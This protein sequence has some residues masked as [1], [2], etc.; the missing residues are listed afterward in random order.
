MRKCI[1]F[2][3]AAV[4]CLLCVTMTGC[5]A[6]IPELLS[7]VSSSD[8]LPPPGTYAVS[9]VGTMDGSTMFYTDVGDELFV[10]NP[11]GT[12]SF[13]YDGKSY[14]ILLDGSKLLVDGEECSYRYVV[15]ETEE[16]I[17]FLYWARDD[18]N[19]I[20]LRPVVG[21]AL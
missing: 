9:S 21:E 4:L 8:Q 2:L 16:E 10:L 7:P 12:G 11:D 20:A 19:S 1:R 17:L 3:T 5:C 15:L 14:E 13:F 6:I 18:T